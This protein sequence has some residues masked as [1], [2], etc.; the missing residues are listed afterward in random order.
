[1]SAYQ[2][3]ITLD[4]SGTATY[5]AV[6]RRLIKF[7]SYLEK[8]TQLPDEFQSSGGY[9][10]YNKYGE[11][12]PPHF[13]FHFYYDHPNLCDVSREL[14]R[15]VKIQFAKSDIILRG[16]HGPSS[17]SLTSVEEN[18]RARWFRYPLKETPVHKLINST[19]AEHPPWQEGPFLNDLIMCAR[20]ERKRSIEANIK[21]REKCREKKTLKDKLFIHLDDLFIITNPN[22]TQPPPPNHH[23]LWV[24]V[25][26]YYTKEDK[27]LNFETISGYAHLYQVQKGHI[28]PSLAYNIHYNNLPLNHNGILQAQEI[29]SEEKTVS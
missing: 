4:P 18:D 24:E 17:F 20:D 12:I 23:D 19:L 27:P 2:L 26:K 13:H 25:L 11:P 22:H 21:H 5:D 15:Q 3:R 6:L 7:K 14:K 10:V 16:A 1:M 29:P 8:K 28:T 9:E